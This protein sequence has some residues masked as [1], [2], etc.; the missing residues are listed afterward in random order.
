MRRKRNGKTEK[1]NGATVGDGLASVGNQDL[2]GQ[3]I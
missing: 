1:K 3:F 2:L